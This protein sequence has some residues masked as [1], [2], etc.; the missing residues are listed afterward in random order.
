M[1]TESILATYASQVAEC[2]KMV[3][4]KNKRGD[5]LTAQTFTRIA[6]NNKAFHHKLLGDSFA[7][8]IETI[9][10]LA[11]KNHGE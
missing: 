1:N 9:Y 7:N 3:K 8:R 10:V 6:Y 5:A 2:F 4:S 11:A